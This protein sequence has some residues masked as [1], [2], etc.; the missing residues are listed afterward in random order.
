LRVAVIGARRVRQGTGEYVA[1]ELAALGAQV[2][3]IVGTSE[4]SVEEARAGLRARHGLEVRGYTSLAALLERE[5]VD[6][7]AICSPHE[8]HLEQL[9]LAVEARLHV[10]AEKPLLW[11]RGLER[12]PRAEVEALVGGLVDRCLASDC[13]LHLNAQW[14]YTLPAFDALHP[15]ARR[16]PARSFR[17][18][19]APMTRGP[20]AV[21][22]A[23]SHLISMLQALVGP[24]DLVDAR[25]TARD[26][27][28]DELS[29][30][31]SYAHRAGTTAVEL[32]LRRCP[33]PP[34]PAGYSI[35]DRVAERRIELPSYRF[36]FEADGRTVPLGDP[37]SASVE[38]FVRSVA[39]ARRPDRAS[40]VA[41][42]TQLQ[43]LV[44]AVDGVCASRSVSS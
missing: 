15:G 37:L 31:A 7:V 18:W 38:D 40:L 23:G 3:A 6:A 4:A 2:P 35:D 20:D 10:F 13:Y 5:A 1:R 25:L 9:E 36:T 41:G 22:D 27:A 11:R 8:A 12:A 39:T 17:M 16:A 24:G 21:V 32:E 42:M 43:E 26:A 14:P 29:L 34:R 44:A 33:A 30:A 19:L 28:Q